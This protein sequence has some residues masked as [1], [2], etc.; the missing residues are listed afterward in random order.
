MQTNIMKQCKKACGALPLPP[1]CD[2]AAMAEKE[3]SEM[4]CCSLANGT[5]VAWAEC[6]DVPIPTEQTVCCES[7]KARSWAAGCRRCC[8]AFAPP[9]SD[10]HNSCDIKATNE[11]GQL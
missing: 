1:V 7:G 9:N 8:D 11:C 4:L 6:K 5:E 10:C 3:F 2:P